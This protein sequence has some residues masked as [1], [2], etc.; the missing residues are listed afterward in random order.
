MKFLVAGPAP[1]LR[2]HDGV[3]L[4]HQIQFGSNDENDVFDALYAIFEPVAVLHQILQ[5]EHFVHLTLLQNFELRRE[6]VREGGRRK[7]FKNMK[8]E[9]GGKE[10]KKI[11]RGKTKA[12][13]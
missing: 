13:S 11:W 6:R 7:T 1:L 8:R 4:L 9:E 2:F 10:K 12:R 3:N 5:H